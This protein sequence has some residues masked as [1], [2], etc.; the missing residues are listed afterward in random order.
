[1]FGDDLSGL[2][3]QPSGTS[4]PGVLWAVDNGSLTL[5]RLVWN[6]TIWAPDTA[7]GWTTGK[8]LRFPG[9]SEVRTP[10]A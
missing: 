5:F 1:M 7:N 6:G 2:A 8:I 9:G 3:Y 10:R 4:A